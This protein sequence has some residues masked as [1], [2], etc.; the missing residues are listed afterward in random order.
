MS[1]GAAMV[2]ASLPRFAFAQATPVVATQYGSVQGATECGVSRFLGLRYAQPVS[3]ANRFLPP[4]PPAPSTEVFVA[5]RHAD[6]TPQ[7]PEPVDATPVTPA[8][9]PP[10]YV[11]GGR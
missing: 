3:G 8:F 1:G 7:G 11:E 4:Q 2:Q 9:A 6:T 5:D 10:D